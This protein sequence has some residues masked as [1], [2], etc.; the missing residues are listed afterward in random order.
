MKNKTNHILT[1]A[2]TLAFA[3]ALCIAADNQDAAKHAVPAIALVQK[4]QAKAVIVLASNASAPERTA[5]NELAAYLKR[6]TGAEFAIVTP[7][8]AAGRPV[9]A[10]GPG[11][12]KAVAP[13]LDLTKAGDKGLGEDGIVLKTVGRNLVLT[14]AGIAPAAEAL[15]QS[16]PNLLLITADDLGMELSCY[17]ETRVATPRLDALAAD[18]VRFLNAYVPQSSCSPARGALLTGRWPHQNGLVGLAHLG[19]RMHP[20]QPSLT[21]LLHDAGYHT[22]II[23]KLHVAPEVNFPFDWVP[24]LQG[25]SPVPTRNVRWVAEPSRTILA[26][27][28]AAVFSAPASAAPKQK[29][30]FDCDLAGDVDDAYAV[31]LLLAS[32]E[33]EVLG[34]VMDHGHTWGRAR[35]TGRLLY[36]LGLEQKVPIVVGRPTSA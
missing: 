29:V 9:I 27:A 25:M 17:G 13:D 15:P 28:L 16:K 5:A 3:S 14:G 2:I 30:L 1:A 35:V 34:L 6:L 21:R 26:V 22:G 8:D 23:G 31:A 18:G 33:F 11:A 32:P 10:D 4:G 19:F 20:D 7:A 36:E 12:A 24:K